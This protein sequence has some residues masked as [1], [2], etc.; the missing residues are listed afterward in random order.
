MLCPKKAFWQRGLLIPQVGASH[1]KVIVLLFT[2][3]I[4]CNINILLTCFV[5]GCGGVIHADTGTIKSPN[6]PQNFPA[7]SECSWQIIAHE[8]SHL[9][10][11][12]NGDFQIPDTTGSCQNSYIKVQPTTVLLQKPKVHRETYVYAE[13]APKPTLL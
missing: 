9:E 7:N 13:A 10:M 11:S 2:E 12:F 8:G 5:P 3:L 1:T 4:I 6:Y